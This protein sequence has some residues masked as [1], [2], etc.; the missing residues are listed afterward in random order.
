M[1]MNYADIAKDSKKGM[2]NTN[3]TDIVI[4]PKQNFMLVYRRR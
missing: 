4:C 1:L 3:I 2:S